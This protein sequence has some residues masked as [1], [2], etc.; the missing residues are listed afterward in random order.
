MT[1]TT[2][3][4]S[5]GPTLGAAPEVKAKHRAMWALGDYPAVAHDIVAPLGPVL[6]R[7]RTALPW[8]LDEAP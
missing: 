7:T 6:D 2:D 8:L 5:T 3:H 4:P 1:S